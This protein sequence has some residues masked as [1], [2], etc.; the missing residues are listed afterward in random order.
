MRRQSG[1]YGSNRLSGHEYESTT[2]LDDHASE[3]G[4]QAINR[5]ALNKQSRNLQVHERL[6]ALREICS[7]YS[8]HLGLQ[9]TEVNGP[10]SREPAIWQPKFLLVGLSCFHVGSM[11]FDSVLL[12]GEVSQ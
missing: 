9:V 2:Y 8:Q 3:I 10:T 1:Y 11:V 12:K 7:C 5:D 4:R 6:I